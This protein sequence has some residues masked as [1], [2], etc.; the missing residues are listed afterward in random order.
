MET[1]YS[2]TGYPITHP[3]LSGYEPAALWH[4]Q[5]E[6][7]PERGKMPENLHVL[8]RTEFEKRGGRTVIRLRP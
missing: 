6:K 5:L 2:F 1:G 4:R 7:A 3:V 8:F